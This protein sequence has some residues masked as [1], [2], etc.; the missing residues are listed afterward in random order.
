MPH[1]EA[2]A[3]AGIVSLA[4]TLFLAAFAIALRLAGARVAA[5]AQRL[6]HRLSP[7]LA[8]STAS[9]ILNFSEGLRIVSTLREFLYALALSVVM[10]LAIALMYL[11]STHAFRAS[12]HLAGLSFA[13]V[14]LLLASSMGGSLLQL[15]IL[16]WFTQIAVLAAALHGFFNV[17]LATASACGAVL[18]TVGNLTV[19]PAGLIAAR[20]Q[21]ITLRD[22]AQTGS[23][24]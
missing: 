21:G 12:P 23:N 4:A 5:L 2:F 9:Q 20:V 14:M 7:K 24:E 19:I 15:P 17:P 1:H 22:A 3:R 8:Q 11:E 16:G 6:L 13:A 10:W 18:L